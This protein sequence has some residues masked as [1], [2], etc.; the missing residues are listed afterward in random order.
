MTAALKLPFTFDPLALKSD[1]EKIEPHEWVNHF[2]PSY[3]EGIWS[4]VALR[5]VNGAA[6]QL[7]A[8][9]SKSDA[10]TDTQVLDRC[11]YFK[12][13]LG[14]FKC[15]L[16]TVRLLKLQSGSR[17]REHRDFDLGWRYGVVR[18]HLPV[19][20]NPGIEFFLD[21]ERVSMNEG[22]SWYLDLALPHRVDN[23]GETD[24]VHLVMDCVVNEWIRAL[25]Q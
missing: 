8:D 25:I 21:G 22:E 18:V 9:P 5:S 12:Q 23:N 16:E 15:S 20:T 4:G 11:C 13:V 14:A 3:Y 10:Y 7:Y 6:S 17:I 19:Q 1:L 24:R 2:N